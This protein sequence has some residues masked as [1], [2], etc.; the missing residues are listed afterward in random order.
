M[1]RK[2]IKKKEEYS[3]EEILR[4]CS[5]TGYLPKSISHK[6]LDK[7][8]Y[9]LYEE[10]CFYQ[11]I[12]DAII[13]LNKKDSDAIFPFYL[14]PSKFNNFNKIK[15]E[16]KKYYLDL[17]CNNIE[18]KLFKKEY[19]FVKKQLE[20]LKLKLY[21][22]IRP[23]VYGLLKKRFYGWIQWHDEFFSEI[24]LQ[25]LTE[26]KKQSYVREKGPLI[27][28][29][30]RIFYITSLGQTIYIQKHHAVSLE[31]LKER[32]SYQIEEEDIKEAEI[33]E[34]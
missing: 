24:F 21:Y 29:L 33:Y 5:E 27:S 10:A 15:N 31:E 8:I 22:S 14:K 16:F 20:K 6:D 12:L 13:F 28:F 18:I 9:S 4:Y 25:I 11:D 23:L 7:Y 17:K 32:D 26:L 30:Y 3:I 19:E 34:I 2:K 1:P